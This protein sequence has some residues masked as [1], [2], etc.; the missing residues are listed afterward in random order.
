[1][2]TSTIEWGPMNDDLLDKLDEAVESY[3]GSPEPQLQELGR[4]LDTLRLE[5][6][7]V[8]VL[9]LWHDVVMRRESVETSLDWD[10]PFAPVYLRSYPWEVRYEETTNPCAR[11]ILTTRRN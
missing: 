6:E 3:L 7:S 2:K 9:G 10:D 5:V 4:A 11:M 8:V 1:M